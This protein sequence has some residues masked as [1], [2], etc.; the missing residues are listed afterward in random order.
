MAKNGV[1]EHPQPFGG[2]LDF[3][4]RAGSSRRAFYALGTG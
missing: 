2:Y 3:A 4:C 1:S